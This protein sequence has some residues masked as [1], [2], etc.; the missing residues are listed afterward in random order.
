MENQKVDGNRVDEQGISYEDALKV[1]EIIK[2][3]LEYRPF[4]KNADLRP[5]MPREE[6]LKQL[7]TPTVGI[8][9]PDAE[10]KIPCLFFRFVG[11][12]GAIV[13]AIFYPI[14]AVYSFLDEARYYVRLL[15]LQEWS[16]EQKE[17]Y[18]VER[19]ID[20]TLMMIDNFYQRG[21][22]MMDSFTVEVIL[23]WR[24]QKHQEVLQYTAEQGIQP[25]R[26]K[27]SS[28]Q[29]HINNYGK[30]VIQLWKYQGQ[31]HDNWRKMQLVENYELL[32][33]HWSYLSR[34]SRENEDWREYAKAGKF[35]DTPDDLIDRLDNTDRLDEQV[36]KQ[37]VSELAIEHAA[38][39]VGLIKKFGVDDSIL[40]KRS[41]GVKITGYSSAKLFE[42]LKEGKQLKDNLEK[43]NELL[44]QQE[45]PSLPEQDSESV[46]AEKVKSLEQKFDYVK[47]NIN[48][49]VEQNQD[50]ALP[51]KE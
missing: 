15:N 21:K 23:Q 11:D 16:D 40:E 2:K 1:F 9:Y 17:D 12:E 43:V 50:S 8:Y 10:K 7:L 19:A 39:R 37:K 25:E 32:Y 4:I 44:A 30:D 34:Q 49:S 27:D 24:Q 6:R 33:K 18:A 41:K 20:M 45:P 35:Q 3:S 29:D 31:S 48:K 28:L 13:E 5:D 51:K 46:L 36:V 42:F 47:A 22:L 38:R 14:E 26:Q